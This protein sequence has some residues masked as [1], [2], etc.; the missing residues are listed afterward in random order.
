M[1]E[2]YSQE[3]GWSRGA[4]G[5]VCSGGRVQLG[6]CGRATV[7]EESVVQRGGSDESYTIDPP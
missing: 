3:G 7:V 4:V 2:G 1:G 5:K 6:F